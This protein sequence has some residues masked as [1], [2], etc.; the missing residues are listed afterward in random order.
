MQPVEVGALRHA[1]VCVAGNQARSPV[2]GRLKQGARWAVAETRPG[3]RCR[4]RRERPPHRKG[5]GQ[6]HFRVICRT[7]PNLGHSAGNPE[8]SQTPNA[9][10]DL[11]P[12]QSD[13]KVILGWFTRTGGGRTTCA[14]SPED[15]PMRFNGRGVRG[16][17][18]VD[19]L[20]RAE[21][22]ARASPNLA[23]LNG[24][25]CMVGIFAPEQRLQCPRGL[26]VE[27]PR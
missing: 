3:K 2:C 24:S 22:R 7:A 17:A 12:D 13:T 5:T 26:V 6:N 27:L 19:R 16:V 9:H 21:V 11:P 15:C 10:A 4:G 1:T 20:P 8:T 25:S 14:A 18:G 23:P